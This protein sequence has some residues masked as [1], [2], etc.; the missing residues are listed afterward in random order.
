[1]NWS[2][3][4]LALIAGAPPIIRGIIR[5]QLERKAKREGLAEITSAF[6][7]RWNPH[8]GEHVRGEAVRE[9]PAEAAFAKRGNNPILDAFPSGNDVHLFPEGERLEERDACSAWERVATSRDSSG[10]ARVLYVH[11]PFCRARCSLCP[12]YANRWKEDVA[13]VYVDALVRELALLDGLPIMSL[14]FD[15]VYFGGGTPSDLPPKELRRLLGAI[16]RYVPLAGDVEVTLEGRA[17]GHSPELTGEAI[18]GGVN[19]FSVGI[20]SFDSGLRRS[21]GRMESKEGVIEFLGRLGRSGAVVVADFIYGLPGQTQTMWEEDLRLL[22]EE[23]EL[24]GMDLYRLKVIPGSPLSKKTALEGVEEFQRRC[25]GFFLR[26]GNILAGAGWRQISVSH[27]RRDIR[28]R[29]RYNSLVKSGADCIPIGCGAGGRAGGIRFFQTGDLSAY[30]S[31][32]RDGI[33]PIAGAI[34]LSEGSVVIDR[35]AE[36]FDRGVLHPGSWKISENGIR[37]VVGRV[38]HQWGGTGL[39]EEEPNGL[40]KLTPAGQFH[41]VGMG[42]RLAGVIHAASL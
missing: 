19:R 31:A 1:M 27:W 2:A 12:F 9:D 3:E 22:T 28:E 24:G 17:H 8:G 10:G 36:D 35:I 39:L 40:L 29:S 25:A 13:E 7:N 16:R 14:P 6:V 21:L 37:E 26:G 18:D 20:Q 42:A 34:R 15:A 38:L 41:S 5:R 32:V 30:F 33:K 4:A 23:T 11:I